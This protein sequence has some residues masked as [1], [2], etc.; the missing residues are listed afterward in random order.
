MALT[1]PDIPNDVVSEGL[2][3]TFL[4]PDNEELEAWV[5]HELV[6]S[7]GDLVVLRGRTWR[8]IERRF[9]L[10][11]IEPMSNRLTVQRGNLTLTLEQP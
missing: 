8:V 9:L 1:A 6:P 2:F 10:G 11:P 7:R 5:P 4:I 3:V